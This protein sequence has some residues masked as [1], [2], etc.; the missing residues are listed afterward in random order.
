MK[1]DGEKRKVQIEAGRAFVKEDYKGTIEMATGTGKTFI[2]LDAMW[3]CPKG[4]VVVFLAETTQREHDLMTD[5]ANYKKAFGRDILAHIELEFAC[6]QSACKWKGRKIYLVVADEIHDSLTPVYSQFYKNND[7]VRILGLSATVQS[8]QVYEIDG[9]EVSKEVLLDEIA[10]VCFT[11]D[12]GDG[13]RRG[14]SRKLNI[15]L[16]YHRLDAAKKNMEGGNKKNRFMTTEQA[17]YNYL[18]KL[19]QQAIFSKNDGMFKMAAGKRARFLYAFPSKIEAVKKLLAGLKGK[20]IIFG[21]D[22]DAMEE[23]TPNVVR[24]AK[25]GIT[26]KSQQDKINFSLRNLFDLGKIA[27]IGSFKMLK[28]GANLKGADNVIQMS[29]YSTLSDFVQ[30]IGRLRVN[31]DKMG[32]VFIM[33]TLGTQEEK[34]F[35]KMMENVPLDEFTVHTCRNVDDCLNKVKNG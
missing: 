7:Y 27:V 31:G 19:F 32:N 21:N 12:I 1:I 20:T 25:K 30:R 5:I 10:P 22:L 18:N 4:S 28:Q 16:V 29:Y 34:W 11:Y 17:Q 9:V 6:Y 2:S 26:T 35:D 15:Y 23:I 13:Q 14:T 33:I 24:S 3:E 8:S